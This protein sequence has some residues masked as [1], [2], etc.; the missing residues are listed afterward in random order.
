MK[1]LENAAFKK[2]ERSLFIAAVIFICVLINPGMASGEPELS[3]YFGFYE[4]EFYK[5]SSLMRSLRHCDVNGDKKTDIAFLDIEKTQLAIL[6][7]SVSSLESSSTELNSINY[8]GRFSRF[9]IPLEKKVYDFAFLKLSGDTF[10]SL[11]LLAEPRWLILMRQN[12][13]MRFY[14]YSKVQL[15]ESN[16]SKSVFSAEDINGDG[17]LDIVAMCPDFFIIAPNAPAA[18]FLKGVKYLPINSEYGNDP[19][20]FCVYDINYD[21][22]PDIVYSYYTKNSNLRIKFASAGGFLN[23]E[24]YDLLS[25]RC[26]DFY[27]PGSGEVRMTSVLESSNRLYAYKIKSASAEAG[28]KTMKFTTSYCEK[29]DR[30]VKN[31]YFTGD[32][33]SDS[34]IDCM[35]VDPAHSKITVFNYSA[36]NRVRSSSIFPFISGAKGAFLVNDAGGAAHVVARDK[37]KLYSSRYDKTARCLEFPVLIPAFSEVLCAS[38][39]PAPLSGEIAVIAR[40]SSE[41]YLYAFDAAAKKMARPKLRIS[42]LLE[43][44][45]DMKIA[46]SAEGVS[47]FIVYSKYDGIKTFIKNESGVFVSVSASDKAAFTAANERNSCLC[48]F[49]ADGADELV[50][51]A[52]NILK[53]YKLDRSNVLFSQKDQ[54]NIASPDFS[55]DSVVFQKGSL[56]ALDAKSKRI[57]R[58]GVKTKEKEIIE[59]ERKI[60]DSSLLTFNASPMIAGDFEI[61]APIKSHSV[62]FDVYNVSAYEENKNGKYNYL[63]S[64]DVN[65]DGV[66]DIVTTCGATNFLDIFTSHRGSLRHAFRFKIFS[67]RQFHQYDSYAPEP[68]M[69][70]IADFNGDGYNDI[71]MLVHD[72]LI[73]YYSDSP[74]L[75]GEIKKKPEAKK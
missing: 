29:N 46:V 28:N 2:Y 21:K 48:D 14:E 68:Q 20:E 69:F 42:A 47:W 32:I 23:E 19:S 60:A 9:N 31:Y 71:A 51:S 17:V 58:Y 16:F 5:G 75:S 63:L 4:V 66:C 72:K 25:F 26:M 15:D 22:L 35:A 24:S 37:D 43:N 74:L 45:I 6:L 73:I 3:K 7:N 11:V 54:I 65:G 10:E 27:S 59:I 38:A 49:D 53:I 33:D 8:S 1:F 67:T 64:R 50:I 18:E 30:D 39:C 12:E 56:Y 36:D 44:L 13:N 52:G 55:A 61:N 41:I 34:I 62:E 57:F 40:E 70:D